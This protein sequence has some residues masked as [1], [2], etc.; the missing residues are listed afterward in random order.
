ML[1]GFKDVTI[2]HP[3]FGLSNG[4]A[5]VSGETQAKAAEEDA[6]QEARASCVWLSPA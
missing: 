5:G 3:E 6:E 4:Q 1:C 2:A